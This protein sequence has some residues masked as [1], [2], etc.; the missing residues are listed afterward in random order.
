MKRTFFWLVGLLAT[1]PALGEPTEPWVTKKLVILQSTKSYE[2]AKKTATAA[3][4]HLKKPVRLRDLKPNKKRGLTHSK[5][6]CAENGYNW[7]CY[8]SRGRYDDGAY[9]SIEYSSAF[10]GWTDGYYVVI[11]A[12]AEKSDPVIN[13]TLNKAK[14]RWKDAYAKSAEI[15]LGCM[16]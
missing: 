3:G 7:P 5:K 10:N 8:V 16:H 9:I 1:P 12:S 15:W 4:K 14:K 2:S 11:A 6:E 13:K